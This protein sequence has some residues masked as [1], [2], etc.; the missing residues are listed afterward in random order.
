[1]AP[2]SVSLPSPPESESLLLPPSS[3]SSPMPPASVSL[4]NPPISV[5]LPA[6]PSS[7]SLPLA[8]SMT[9]FS[10]LPE[11]VAPTLVKKERFSML[12]AAATDK[13]NADSV[14]MASMPC[15]ASSTILS[16][17]SNRM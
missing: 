15:P 17:T 3:L 16:P 5:S 2:S 4:P 8:P 7:E 12:A 14:L 6:A 9:L 11:P 1:M 13:S 10:P